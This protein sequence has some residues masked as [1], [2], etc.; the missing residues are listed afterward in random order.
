MTDYR[1]ILQKKT[2]LLC[3]GIYLDK[4]LKS[5]Y[6]A[7]GIDLKYGRKG[8]A[9]PL[10]GRYFLFEDGKT[11]ANIAMWDT[12]E[13][14]SLKLKHQK[15]DIFEIYDLSD[16]GTFCILKLVQEPKYYDPSYKTSDGVEMRKIALVHGVDCVA[17]TVYQKCKYWKCGEACRFCGIELSLKY[18]STILEKTPAQLSE[19]VTQA[20]KEGRC[21][22][23]TLT[24]GTCEDEDKG[25]DRYMKIL[26][27]L[28]E[29]HPHIPLHIQI[30]PIE[31]LTI[32]T[33]LHDAGADTVGIHIEIL[34]DIVRQVITPGK[35]KIPYEEFVRNWK[36]A[37]DVFGRSQVETFILTGFGESPKD[38][39]Q[40]L[41]E[42]VSIGIVPFITPVRP[43]PKAHKKLPQ[44]NHNMLLEIYNKAAKLMKKHNVNPLIHKA[45]CVRCGGCSAISEAYK[46][47]TQQKSISS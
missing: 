8:G 19:V 17:S 37:V 36:C 22:H 7:H 1:Q 41:E 28:K 27:R 23:L 12:K 26:E 30:E 9:G 18:D 13:K 4:E 40:R 44:M 38:F 6:R 10:G 2:Q 32:Y 29:D 45:G 21:A 15:D 33:A 24:S 42:V 46:A 43:I 47:L 14:S 35:A 31:D 20:K 3:Q 11:L 5:T 39:Q 16:K 34:D 25:A